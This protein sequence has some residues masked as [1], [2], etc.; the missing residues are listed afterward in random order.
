MV[1]SRRNLLKS[2]AALAAGP[3][4]DPALAQTMLSGKAYIYAD[5]IFRTIPRELYGIAVDWR[6][7]LSGLWRVDLDDFDPD[8][9]RLA[10]E[11]RPALVRFPGGFLTDFYHWKDGI[12]PRNQRTA[13]PAWTDGPLSYPYVGTGE[14]LD[15]SHRTGAGLLFSVNAGT[16]NAEEAG[17]WV[18]YVNGGSPGRV[19]FWE[20]GNELY[21]QGGFAELYVTIP[22][23]EYAARFRQFAQTMRAQDPTIQ[24]GAIAA[25]NFG[26]YILNSYPGWNYTLLTAAGD[27]IDFLSVHNSYAPVNIFDQNLDVRTVYTAMLAAPRAIHRNLNTI[28]AEID[29]LVPQRAS[30]I[31]LAITEWSPLFAFDPEPFT[32][33]VRTL[34]SAIYIA[35]VLKQFIDVPKVIASCTFNFVS[36]DFISWIGLR[37]GKYIPNCQY[38]ALQMFTQHFGSKRVLSF[39]G[40]PTFDSAT[41]GVIQAETGVPYLDLTV[42]VNEDR[43]KLYI[44]G[45]NKHFDAPIRMNI[46]ISGFR[47]AREGIAWTLQGTGI[48]SNTGT[49]FDPAW[50]PQAQDSVNPQFYLGSPDAVTISSAPVGGISEQFTYTFPRF[51]VTSIEIPAA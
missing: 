38:L 47:P 32:L 13:V 35:S 27:D 15:F 20:V 16:G 25:E 6:G 39:Y 8:V 49:D 44:M 42:S 29:L 10:A 51:S 41:V 46:S 2:L 14:M 5:Q 17:G 36:S 4:I 33:H 40:C 31:G 48:D 21:N 24:I 7:D 9:V 22:P 34:G 26:A 1:L 43:S 37:D 12:G 28:A 23:Q 19:K 50:G 30:Q 3:G 18:Q 45:I 11:L